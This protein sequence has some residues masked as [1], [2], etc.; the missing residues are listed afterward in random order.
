[1]TAEDAQAAV[2][3]ARSS[4]PRAAARAYGVSITTIYREIGR[5]KA[6]KAGPS[7]GGRAG[8]AEETSC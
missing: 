5:A 1:M 6:A 3:L 8:G 4:T 2:D 7:A